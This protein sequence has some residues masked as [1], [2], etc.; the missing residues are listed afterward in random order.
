[1]GQETSAMVGSET[2]ASRWDLEK[3]VWALGE[4][5]GLRFEAA[6]VEVGPEGGLNSVRKHSMM[7]SQRNG[8]SCAILF[9]FVTYL[10]LINAC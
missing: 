2:P 3:D 9:H 1:M 10:E 4:R 6:S 7:F 8:V 5:G